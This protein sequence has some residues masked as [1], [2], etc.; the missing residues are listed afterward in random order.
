MD[1][2]LLKI[3]IDEDDVVYANTNGNHLEIAE[4]IST[5]MLMDLQFA[6][7]I[8]GAVDMYYKH[9]EDNN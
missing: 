2:E 4:C 5:C 6:A 1:T 7:I 9:L 8:I 3:S